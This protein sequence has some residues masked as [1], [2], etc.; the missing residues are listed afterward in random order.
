[1]AAKERK[2]THSTHMK[3]YSRKD[4]KA[5][6]DQTGR[7]V[8]LCVRLRSFA[9]ALGGL[10]T[11]RETIWLSCM[12]IFLVTAQSRAGEV[13]LQ[14]QEP[15]AD[16]FGG[17][18]LVF[19]AVVSGD[20][21]DKGIV[22]WNLSVNQRTVQS[23]DQPPNGS[24]IIPVTLSI[25]EIMPGIVMDGVLTLSYHVTGGSVAATSLARRVWLFSPDPFSGRIQWLKS[26]DIRLFDPEGGTA[27]VLEKAGIPFAMLKSVDAIS[28]VDTGMVV[29]GECTHMDQQRGLADALM[30]VASAGRPVLCLAPAG[31]SI[32]L[33]EHA[34]PE[35]SRGTVRLQSP[36][37]LTFR[38][39]DVITNFDKRL[40]SVVVKSAL[41]M[42]SMRDT[43]QGQFSA[44]GQWPWVEMSFGTGGRIVFCGF[45][46]I[47]QWDA[48]PAPRYVLNAILDR[49]AGIS[50]D[51]E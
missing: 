1:M 39:S 38:Q 12:F 30:R 51:K 23:G 48:N 2:E 18:T 10:A 26:L 25:P 46:L 19:H 31:G 45:G 27:P 40:D 7:D 22:S 4:A 3:N 32:S 36:S 9:F 33:E 29:V 8:G 24:G 28:Q 49:L 20:G 5:L 47:D 6:S 15:W 42:V 35:L 50:S 13:S 44:D 16:V 17:T 14:F 43:V 37:S 21:T 41:D 11:W 34:R